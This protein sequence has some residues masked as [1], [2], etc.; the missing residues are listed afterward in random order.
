MIPREF[1]NEL[2]ERADLVEA[3]GAHVKLE[4][5]GANWVGLCPFHTEKTGSFTVQPAKGFYHCFG[6]GAHGNIISFMMQH[7]NLDF[8]GALEKLA[9]AQGRTLP[10]GRGGSGEDAGVRA[11][12]TA[13]L[14]AAAQYFQRQLRGSEAAKTYLKGRGLTGETAALYKIGYAPNEWDGIKRELKAE[15]KAL[16][17]I[18]LVR[19][20]DAKTYDYF[21][22]RIIFPIID[23][24]G[25]VCGFG[26]RAMDDSDNPKYLNSEDSGHFSKRRLLFGLP[27]AMPAARRSKRLIICEG[28]MDVVMLAQGGFPESVAT[29]GTA[30][31]DQ[32]M[33]KAAQ[34]AENLYLAYDGDGAGRKGAFRA[35]QGI[36]AA[37]K[38]GV[39]V[40]FLFLPDGHDPDSYIR[41]N[42]ADAFEQLLKGAQPLGDYLVEALWQRA[43]AESDEGR[44][45]SLCR[46]GAQLLQQI[47]RREAA[48][49]HGL[50]KKRLEQKAGI[51]L[52]TGRQ[53][54][55]KAP[56]RA[57]G[58]AFGMKSQS[59]FLSLLGCLAARPALADGL[60]TDL[61][62]PG[63]SED[64]VEA[65]GAVLEKLRWHMGGEESHEEGAADAAESAGSSVPAIL[66]E[67]GYA[68]LAQQVR[69]HAERLADAQGKKANIKAELE[70][71]VATLQ[72]KHQRRLR[73]GKEEWL[74]KMRDGSAAST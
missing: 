43:A 68:R 58:A 36:L 29:M 74:K 64:E 44:I 53:Q 34:L 40:F 57:P 48:A 54:G 24:G 1:I 60:P 66:E 16:V 18:G 21:R 70:N 4:R 13:L 28:Y 71:I 19:K 63:A 8:M 17:D 65:V 14:Q 31:T 50:L 22:N 38:D 73:P 20:K 15:E 59:I 27:Q 23:G 33:R 6:C 2:I 62:L 9:A 42:G 69:R 5:K 10:R 37:L 49:W 52:A 41:A 51:P 72:K 12:K 56:R 55:A 39:S 67:K 26:G 61:P 46:E 45:T 25:R 32:Q 35:L 30:A 47:G 7:Q 11:G 3:I